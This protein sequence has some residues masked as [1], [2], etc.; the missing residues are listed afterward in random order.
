[1]AIPRSTI[2]KSKEYGITIN[3]PREGRPPNMADQAMRALIREATKR[4][5][6]IL[7]ELLSSTAEV[8]ISVHRTTLSSTLQS[9]AFKMIYFTFI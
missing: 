2:K 1:V 6:I 7:K 9:W 8:G 5:K 3:L 4:P